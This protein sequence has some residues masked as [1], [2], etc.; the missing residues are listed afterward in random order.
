MGPQTIVRRGH[1]QPGVDLTFIKQSGESNGAAGGQYAG[2]DAFGRVIDQRW[3]GTSSGT[4][5]DRFQY[6]Y[7]RDS[8]PV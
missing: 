8:N 3:I 2:L 7:D 4:A 5:T 1:S 6:G